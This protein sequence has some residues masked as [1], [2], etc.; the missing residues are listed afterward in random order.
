MSLTFFIFIKISQFALPKPDFN[1]EKGEPYQPVQ[2]LLFKGKT[3]ETISFF[4]FFC[5]KLRSAAG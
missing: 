4:R 1:Q 5:S 3:Y 2:A